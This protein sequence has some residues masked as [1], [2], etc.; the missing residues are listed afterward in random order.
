MGFVM[1][2]AVTMATKTGL[3]EEAGSDRHRTK[4]NGEGFST[5]DAASREEPTQEPDESEPVQD[6][7]E[8]L[9]RAVRS[10][11]IDLVA[12][13]LGVAEG[14]SKARLSRARAKLREALGD[15]MQEYV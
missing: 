5:P 6:D 7:D 2:R 3:I 15:A 10:E 1:R 11:A 13:I 12:D 14:T 9:V 4:A 8:D